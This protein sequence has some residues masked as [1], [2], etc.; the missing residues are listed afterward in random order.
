MQTVKE[1]AFW[2]AIEALPFK[3]RF[4]HLHGEKDYFGEF[5]GPAGQIVGR[6]QATVPGKWVFSLPLLPTV[7]GDGV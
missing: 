4:N 1:A 2:K 6:V 7:E 5:L 3:P